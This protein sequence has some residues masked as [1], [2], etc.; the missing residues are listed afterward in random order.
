MDDH[1]YTPHHNNQHSARSK[2]ARTVFPTINLKPNRGKLVTYSSHVTIAGPKPGTL[3]C[4]SVLLDV[5][6]RVN[7]DV[8]LLVIPRLLSKRRR[9]RPRLLQAGGESRVRIF[10]N[11]FIVP[12]H[13]IVIDPRRPPAPVANINF[14]GNGS[15]VVVH[16]VIIVI[17]VG[18]L[19]LLNPFLQG[20]TPMQLRGNGW[21]QKRAPGKAAAQDGHVGWETNEPQ[22]FRRQCVFWCLVLLPTA[23]HVVPQRSLGA[24]DQ[25]FQARLLLGFHLFRRQSQANGLERLLLLNQ[26][27]QGVPIDIVL[28]TQPSNGPFGR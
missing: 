3:Q 6:L 24:L 22:F 9:R 10:P 19:S 18:R 27:L 17:L 23:N 11:A 25:F 5:T 4:C 8:I 1:E 16:I 26:G 2:T 7:D 21:R 15:V 28:P 14:H 13:Q 20:P 12:Q